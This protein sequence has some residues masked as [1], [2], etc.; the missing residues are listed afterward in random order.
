M[1]DKNDTILFL[2]FV[3]PGYYLGLINVRHFVAVY[4][5]CYN[6]PVKTAKL[7]ECF[8]GLIAR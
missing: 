3:N 4:G 1:N 7:T 8:M 2:R 5:V 6:D